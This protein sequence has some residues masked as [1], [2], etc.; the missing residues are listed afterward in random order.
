[1]SNNF[2]V[3]DVIQDRVKALMKVFSGHL[4]TIMQKLIDGVA[5]TYIAHLFTPKQEVE[6]EVIKE[7]PVEE[8]ERLANQWSMN[9]LSP[10]T[11]NMSLT[12]IQSAISKE[13]ECEPIDNVIEEDLTIPSGHKV[14]EMLAQPKQV[15]KHNE[16]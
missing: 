8:V 1:M 7:S 11:I 16:E 9:H 4:M 5:A 10:R 13:I 3:N 12:S 2:G 6:I 15:S 14:R